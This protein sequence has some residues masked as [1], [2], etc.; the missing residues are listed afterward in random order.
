MKKRNKVISIITICLCMVL[1]LG[2][3]VSAEN[4][5]EGGRYLGFTQELPGDSSPVVVI[6]RNK[7][8][9]KQYSHVI[10]YG[11]TVNKAY[12][13]TT[14]S[15]GNSVSNDWISI[16][17]DL[18]MQDFVS[19]PYNTRLGIGTGVKLMAKQGNILAKTAVGIA[20]IL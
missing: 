4:R 6:S 3:M 1:F 16:V 12:F 17:P 2:V 19:L 10:L 5:V 11:S 13:K 18:D 9:D 14:L 20:S 8:T 15:N 7:S